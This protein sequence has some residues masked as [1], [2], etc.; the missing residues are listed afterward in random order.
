MKEKLPKNKTKQ[1]HSKMPLS[2]DISLYITQT[3]TADYTGN[4]NPKIKPNPPQLMSIHTINNLKIGSSESQL[5]E[6]AV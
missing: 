2:C 6:N 3:Y 5:V 4:N 1:T